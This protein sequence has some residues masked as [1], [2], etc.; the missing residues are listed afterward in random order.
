MKNK[1]ITLCELLGLITE[2]Q[3]PKKIKCDNKIYTFINRDYYHNGE[4]LSTEL[5][6]LFEKF[7]IKELL[8]KKIVEIIEENDEWEDIEEINFLD[9]FNDSYY[10]TCLTKMGDICNQLIKNQK[11]LKERLEEK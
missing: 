2:G 3:A 10:D 1:T 4:W 7:S 8:D 5:S 6:T 11:Y 9:G